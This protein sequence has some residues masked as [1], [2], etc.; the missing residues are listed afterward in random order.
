M[1]KQERL[2]GDSAE[3]AR[4][5]ESD[6][7]DLLEKEIIELKVQNSTLQ[8]TQNMC[9]NDNEVLRISELEEENRKLKQV[10]G[11]ERKKITSEKKKAEEKKGKTLEM[12]KILKSETNKS[13]EYRRV[14]DTER[15]VANDWRASCER[16]RGEVNEVRA[17][18]AAQIQ[19]TEEAVKRVETEKQKVAREKKRADSEKSLAEKSKALI[20]VERKTVTEEKSRADNLFAKLEEQKKLNEDLRTSIQVEIKNTIEEKKRADH[21][22]QKLEE[23]RKQSEYLQRKSNDRSSGKYGW[24]H[25]RS[26]ESA[27]V[28]L[29][30]EKLKLKKEQLKHVKNVSKLD[31]AKNAIIRREFQ[32]LKQDWMQLLSRFNILDDHLAGGVEGIHVLTELQ[33][34]PEIRGFEQ[35]L[36]PNDPVAGPYFGLQ[37]GMVPFGSSI[38]REY[39]SYQLP[40]ESCTRPISG[41]S[42]ELGPPLGSSLRTKSKSLHRSSCPTSISDEKFMGSQGKD[43]LFVSSSTDIRKKQNSVVPELPRKD[44]N[45]TTR[46]DDRAL[47]LEALKSSFPGGTEATDKILGGDR[48]RKRTTKPL[49]SDVCLSSKHDLLHLESKARAATSNEVL[50]FNDDRSGLQQGNKNNIMMCVTEDDMENHRRKY[51]AVADKAPPFGCTA[52]VPSPG[53]GNACVVSKFASLLCF[54]KMIGGSCLKLLNLD[55]DADEDKCRKAMERPHSPNLP[56]IQPRRIKVP[57]YEEP[58]NLSDETLNDCPASGPDAIDSRTR[59]KMLEVK[60]LAI[61]KMTEKGIQLDPTSSRIECSDSVKQL[62]ANDR[63]NAIVNVSCSTKSVGV[64]TNSSLDCLLHKDEART[65]VASSAE[66]SGN[67]STPVL[68]GSNCSGHPDSILHSRHL[69]KVVPNK[70]R[71]SDP[72]LRAVVGTNK[73]KMTKPINLDSNS[74]LRHNSGSEKTPMHIVGFLRMKRGNIVNIFRYWETLTSKAG[75]LYKEASIDGLLLERVSTELLL[76]T[77]EKVSLIFSLLLWDIRFTAKPFVAENFASAFSSSVKSY[78]ETRWTCLKKDQLDVLVS[79]IEDFL[80][81]KEVVVCEKMGQKVPDA[82]KYHNLDGADIQLSTKPATIE[83]FISACILLASICV[84]VERADI[85]LEVSYKV[86]QMGKSN[87]SWT[88]FALHVF[89]SVCGDNFL[90]PKSCNFLMTAIRLVVLLI[91]RKDTSMC[92]VSSYIQKNRP[93]TLPSCAHCL[94]DVDTISIDGFISS[95]LDELGLCSLLWS[96]HANSTMARCSSQ[97]GSSGLEINCGESCN[98]FKQGK[99]AED[100]HNPAGIDLCYFTELISLLELFGIYMSCEWTYNNVVVRLLEILESCT[101]EEYSAALLVLVNQLGRFFADD[102]GYEQRAVSELRN[103]LSLLIG[104]AFTKSKSVAVQFSAIGALLSLLPLPFDKIVAAQSRPFSGPFVLQASQISEWFDQLSKEHQ[105]LAR[106]FFS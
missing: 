95:L 14:A 24:Q 74:V 50:A 92:L 94:F 10:L 91:E 30:K 73:T 68:S 16:L 5:T 35:K 58:H 84:E 18:L 40:R 17:Q 103:K 61:Q 32:C 71:S 51:L 88:L 44:S 102:V 54:E 45:D 56:I 6:A 70:N 98:I 46:Q 63:Y 93:T 78:M 57:T 43:S 13:E 39:T 31:K 64:P 65:S 79:L 59:S 41:T 76:P 4:E 72:G 90:F 82:S 80:V 47:S 27:N 20:E 55:S 15:K 22:L 38:P 104:T 66:E 34:H 75:K 33:Q 42:S 28:K 99:L 36:L 83:Q 49:E 48:K 3:A 26:S 67:T 96:N 2:R 37:S 11:E 23:E 21:L 86:L 85:V 60:E 105:S 100:S 97:L 89:G 19:K 8:Q 53:G 1:C 12:Q 9:K 101:C 69:C 62:C 25:D 81:N 77:E 106:S 29:L 52:K 7:R 87:L